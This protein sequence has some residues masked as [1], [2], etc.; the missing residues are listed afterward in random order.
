MN[1][2]DLRQ[3]YI[4]KE[5]D[6]KD[7]DVNPF[8]QFEKWFAD[9]MALN[10]A[11]PNAFILC[12]S[13]KEGKPSSRIMLLKGVDDKG[14]VFY[15]NY[16]SRKSKEILEN[17]NAAFLFFFKELHRQVRIEGKLEKVSREE[18]EEYFKSRP[19]ESRIG[20]WASAQSSVISS[21]QELE[22]KVKKYTEE[23]S[24]KEVPLP[25]FWG[26]FRLIPEYFE[27]WQGRESRLHDRISYSK[28][29]GEAWKLERLSP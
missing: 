21:R 23:Y 10:I 17:P 4:A 28:S 29:S 25:D 22:D 1:Y 18:S 24:D 2:A 19:L 15:T 6:I 7:C 3:E 20:A 26:G 5:F 27:F 16:L 9:I 8:A 12:T 11:D 13:T 14:F